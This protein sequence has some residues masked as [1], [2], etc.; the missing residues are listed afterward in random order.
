MSPPVLK[1][2][3]STPVSLAAVITPAGKEVSHGGNDRSGLAQAKGPGPFLVLKTP[4]RSRDASFMSSGPLTDPG[5]RRHSNPSIMSGISPTK[6][7]HFSKVRG[8]KERSDELRMRILSASMCSA[9][10]YMSASRE[11]TMLH[12]RLFL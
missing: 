4:S 7:E 2:K 12:E 10:T 1:S 8:G 5:G 3:F 11:A 9:D 6:T